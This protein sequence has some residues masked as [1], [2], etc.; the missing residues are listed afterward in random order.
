MVLQSA[1]QRGFDFFAEKPIVFE[2]SEAQMSSDAGLLVFRQ[3]DEQIGLTEQFV[4]ALE[5]PRKPEFVDHSFEQM[6]RSRIYGILAGYEDQNDHDV[7]RSDPIFKLA[8]DR[9]PEGE[10]LASQP[11][12]SRFENSINIASLKRLRDVFID[13]YLDSLGPCPRRIVLDIDAID[14]PVHGEQQLTFWHGHYD[15]Y[16]YL[17]LA[18]T[19]ATSG[20]F[21]MLSLR[22]GNMHAALGA[23][24]DVEY[25]VRCIRHRWPDVEIALRG[26]AGFGVPWMYDVCERLGVTYTFGL[27]TNNVLKTRSDSLLQEALQ[28]FEETGEPQRLFGG[29]WYRAQSWPADR[30]VIVKAEASANGINRRYL[31]T[32]R[33]GAT[34]LFESTYDDY[35]MRG[36]SEN[37][38]KE[39]KCDLA[40][41]RMSDHRFVANYFRLYLHAAAMNLVIR[42]RRSIADPP[43]SEFASE[44]VPVEAFAGQTRRRYFQ[45]RRQQDPLGEGHPRTWRTLVIKVAGEVTVST[46]RVLV[47]FSSSWPYLDLFRRLC[48]RLS[49]ASIPIP[50]TS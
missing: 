10:D 31:V 27:A 33:P 8:S 36:D 9:C 46:R 5:D 6:T 41:D 15:Q 16:Q 20:Q 43:I 30:W 19:C 48:D 37:R 14:D 45:R 2:P 49:A 26:D 13:Q 11:T 38:N 35:A 39:F 50:N 24:D 25:L 47:R 3:F 1:W 28:L 21:I 42:L 7:L 22:P 4:K 23:D 12:L 17:P 40:M 18:I 44:G 34:I 32:N 29:F